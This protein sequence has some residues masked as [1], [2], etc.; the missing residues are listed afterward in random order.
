MPK[1]ITGKRVIAIALITIAL[2]LTLKGAIATDGISIY[3]S[4]T[5]SNTSTPKMRIWNSTEQGSWTDEFELQKAGSPIRFLILKSFYS[6]LSTKF[7]AVTQNDD[8]LL[9]AYVCKEKCKTASSWKYSEDIGNVTGNTNRRKFDLA[10]ETATGDALIIYGINSTS[11]T[12]DIGFRVLPFN[13]TNISGNEE[14]KLHETTT[15]NTPN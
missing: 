10:F 7:V 1:F 11:T 12:R 15:T 8:H 14:Q 3:R 6:N 9:D 2:V 5:I 13:D 4:T